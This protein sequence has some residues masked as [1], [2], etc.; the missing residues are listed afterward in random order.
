MFHVLMIH[1]GVE[2]MHSHP[3]LGGKEETRPGFPKEL[4]SATRYYA[5]Y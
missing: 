5:R 1:V 3:R 2:R 4:L